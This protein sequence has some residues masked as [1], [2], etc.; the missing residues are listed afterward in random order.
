MGGKIGD[1]G[2]GVCPR[3]SRK[4]KKFDEKLNFRQFFFCQFIIIIII[5]SDLCTVRD[6]EFRASLSVYLLSKN[7]WDDFQ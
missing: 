7:V 2:G 6:T 4:N 3:S 5:M 1:G